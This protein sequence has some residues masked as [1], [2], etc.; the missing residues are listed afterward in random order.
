M[1]KPAPESDPESRWRLRTAFSIAVII[2]IGAALQLLV[3][4]DAGWRDEE[5]LW[6]NAFVFILGG[7][8][9]AVFGYRRT[10]GR[11]P[12]RVYSMILAFCFLAVALGFGVLVIG[13][14]TGVIHGWRSQSIGGLALV[15]LAV[16]LYLAYHCLK[17]ALFPDDKK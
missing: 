11:R 5:W 14:E 3:T 17:D 9:A 6:A 16:C 2:F 12:R 7:I 8:L 1:T 15:L 4:A 10:A 13:V